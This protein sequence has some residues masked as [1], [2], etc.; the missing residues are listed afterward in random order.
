VRPLSAF[1]FFRRLPISHRLC[2]VYAHT[3][4]HSAPI[5]AALDTLL[6]GAVDDV[7]N[8]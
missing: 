3:V 8:M 4:E 2:R 7:T 5:A 6:G 1:E